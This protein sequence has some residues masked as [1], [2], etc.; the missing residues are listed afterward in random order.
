[1]V[2]AVSLYDSPFSALHSRLGALYI[3]FVCLGPYIVSL[4]FITQNTAAHTKKVVLCFIVK[5]VLNISCPLGI[6]ESLGSYIPSVLTIVL[7][8]KYCWNENRRRDRAATAVGG[9][10]QEAH[11]DTDSMDLTDEQNPQFTYAW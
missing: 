3:S 2:D 4:G 7:Y 1:M 11:L 5:C 10:A 9:D 8:M 6:G